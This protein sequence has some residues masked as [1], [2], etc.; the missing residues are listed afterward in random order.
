MTNFAEAV[1][2]ICPKC[3]AMNR[4]KATIIDVEKAVA[5]CRV[6]GHHWEAMSVV[7]QA[8]RL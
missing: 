2:L 7:L 3:Y 8:Q 5:L 1:S 4:Q 6:C